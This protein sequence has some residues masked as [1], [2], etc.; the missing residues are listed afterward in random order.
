[1]EERFPIYNLFWVHREVFCFGFSDLLCGICLQKFT[2]F[3]ILTFLKVKCFPDKNLEEFTFAS[4]DPTHRNLFQKKCKKY[5]ILSKN[6]T[7]LK[8]KIQKIGMRH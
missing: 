4:P 5:A 6:V 3:D 2:T 8:E 7:I 1:M